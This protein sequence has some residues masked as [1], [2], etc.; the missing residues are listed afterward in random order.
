VESIGTRRVVLVRYRAASPAADGSL[1]EQDFVGSGLL[2]DPCTVL[3]ADHVAEGS[4][5]SCHGPDWSSPVDQVV[6]TEDARVDL[7]VLK[8]AAPVAG[9]EP[10]GYARLDRSRI[11]EVAGCVAVGYPR[12][13]KA[14][15]TDARYT[16][17]VKGVVPTAETLLHTATPDR[18]TLRSAAGC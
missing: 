17:Q 14:K 11:A 9:V 1:V 6:R 8:L 10:L 2:V 13:K 15:K 7:A 18:A 16:A 4:G 12:W 5:H 3:T